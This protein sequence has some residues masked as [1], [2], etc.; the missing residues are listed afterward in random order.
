MT[1]NESPVKPPL[2][3]R[4]RTILAAAALVFVAAAPVPSAAFGKTAREEARLDELRRTAWDQGSVRVIVHLNVPRIEDLSAASAAFG[5]RD[6]ST[7][8]ARRRRFAD[9]ALSKAVDYVAWKVATELQ[10]T[11]F[12]ETGR[13]QFFPL[14]GLRVSPGALALLEASA[15]V[16]DIHEDKARKL[17]EPVEGAGSA[18]KG[19]PVENA[20]G[21]PDPPL[22]AD[23]TVLVQAKALWDIGITGAG[24]YVAIL[25]TGIRSSHEFFGGKN[26]IEACRARG[27]DGFAGAGDCPNGLSEQNGP[28]SAAHY[29][30]TYAGWDHGTHVAGI[31][32]GNFGT[33]AGVAKG[34]DIIAVQI[35][36]RFS[37]SDCGTGS[38][39]VMT[40]DSD[41]IAGLEYVYSIRGSYNIAAVNMS[42]GG[43]AYSSFCDYEPQRIAINQL[44]AAGI[45]T[46]IATGNDGYCNYISSPACI[47]SAVSVGSSTKSD[48][49][50]GFNNWSPA[51]QRLFAPGSSILSSTGDSD[52]SY[53]AWSGTS[54]ATPHV[55]GAWALLKQAVPA[56]AVSD[57]LD[58]LQAAGKAV[59]SV[60]DG[61]G[62]SLPRIK[63][64]DALTWMTSF[65]L[66]I[67]AGT[68][69]TTDPV[70]GTYAYPPNASVPVTAV[71]GQYATF[72]DWTGDASGSAN[73]VTVTM[74][75]DQ[76]VR[77]N[78]RYIEAPLAS[79]Q[80]VLNRSFSQAEYIN[81]LSW[82]N[83]PANAGLNITVYRLYVV[84][85]G[86][87]ALL[88]E[89]G[90]GVREFSHRLAGADPVTYRIVAVVSG[91]REG[92]PA[93]I[94]V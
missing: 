4:F 67:Q 36:S 46:A 89:V 85:N 8:E 48:A 38:P 80:R 15:D 26:I 11:D 61:Y 83:N 25:D 88:A 51:L 54:M 81:I 74:D 13:F 93:E 52:S 72:V 31:A 70:P 91:E 49:E 22:L 32:A 37:A 33:R 63:I 43:G 59:Y 18:G 62:T 45:A 60:C 86:T 53:Q 57:F 73:P 21:N 6:G 9:G 5:R 29:A 66:V 71:P 94:T 17:I 41:Q 79:G 40:W 20:G 34:A 47:S 64:F 3:A 12:E 42:L 7:E 50:S 68:Y 90:A 44:R 76:T 82:E 10:G 65:T 30:S 39:C 27:S 16:L 87:P 78:F 2:T 28:N 69:G 58:A 77:A 23:S 75:R 92:A 56:G 35:F 1:R 55:T 84:S 14:L 24:W 19:G